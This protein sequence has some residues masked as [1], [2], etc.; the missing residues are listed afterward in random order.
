MARLDEVSVQHACRSMHM[1]T[2][3]KKVFWPFS[4]YCTHSKLRP[5][6]LLVRFS[7]KGGRG[8]RGG[9]GGGGEGGGAYN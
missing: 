4:L 1:D 5:P 2:D 3:S 6:F 7:Y 8:G 9:G